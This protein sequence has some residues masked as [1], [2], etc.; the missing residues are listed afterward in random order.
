MTMSAFHPLRTLA[1]EAIHTPVRAAGILDM[2]SKQAPV[3]VIITLCA[4]LV[5]A[6]T[7]A[8]VWLARS[9]A[10]IVAGLTLL[11]LATR[12]RRQPFDTSGEADFT[13]SSGWIAH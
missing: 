3:I 1:L 2:L 10:I 5:G 11:L 4:A 8:P 12:K 6:W 9:A 7:G 13:N